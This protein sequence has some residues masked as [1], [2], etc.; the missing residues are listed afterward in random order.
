MFAIFSLTQCYITR[1]Q[2]Q[3][4]TTYTI[5]F[6]FTLK[7]RL[8]RVCWLVREQHSIPPSAQLCP[9]D[10]VFLPATGDDLK[11]SRANNI[12]WCLTPLPSPL[13]THKPLSYPLDQ[14]GVIV[15]SIS[16]QITALFTSDLTH[17]YLQESDNLE[18]S[19]KFVLPL[20][21]S[22]IVLLC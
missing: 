16:V 11:A 10:N 1:W 22:N 3:Y 21:L 17:K 20:D 6:S 14:I 8:R 12:S 5:P 18:H 2:W 19:N 7:R 15:N 4:I 9:V 13:C